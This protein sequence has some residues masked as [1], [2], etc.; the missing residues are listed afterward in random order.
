MVWVGLDRAENLGVPGGYAWSNWCD[1]HVWPVKYVMYPAVRMAVV[2]WTLWPG[3][4]AFVGLGIGAVRATW[5]WVLDRVS[6]L[7]DTGLAGWV[8]VIVV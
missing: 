2:A 3:E 4:M 7:V 8:K 5:H 6:S 1:G